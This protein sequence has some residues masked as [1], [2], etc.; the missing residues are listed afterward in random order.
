MPTSFSLTQ[1]VLI[2]TTYLL[3]LF[4]V[5]W[6]SEKGCGPTLDRAPSHHLY[7]VR[8]AYTPV[9]GHFLAQWA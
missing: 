7:F 9:P 6:A 8:R 1:L 4:G 5:A 2:S 3:T